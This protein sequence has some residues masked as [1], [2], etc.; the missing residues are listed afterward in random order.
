[1]YLKIE[2]VVQLRMTGWAAKYTYLTD[3]PT[4]KKKIR[5]IMVYAKVKLSLQ[6]PL[7]FAI[8]SFCEG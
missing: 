5:Y 7:I 4:K 2:M 6:Q 8:L 1:M 3:W